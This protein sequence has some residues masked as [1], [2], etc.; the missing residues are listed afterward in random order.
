MFARSGVLRAV[1][2]RR[3]HTVPEVKMCKCL[4]W[5]CDVTCG[6]LLRDLSFVLPVCRRRFISLEMVI[7]GTLKWSATAWWVIPVWTIPTARSRSFWRS[8][9][10]DVLVNG[11]LFSFVDSTINDRRWFKCIIWSSQTRPGDGTLT[12]RIFSVTEQD[13]I[14]CFVRI[15]AFHANIDVYDKNNCFGFNIK[16]YFKN[17]FVSFLLV[18]SK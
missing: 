6:L 14:V 8:R 11:K 10:I 16:I 1:P 4:S 3:Y 15:N 5:R 2:F 9:G 17:V 18:T 12:F 7:L 13:D